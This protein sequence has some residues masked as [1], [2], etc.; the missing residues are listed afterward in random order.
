MAEQN[1]RII[2]DRTEESLEMIKCATERKMLKLYLAFN[3]EEKSNILPKI[4]VLFQHSRKNA[5]CLFQYCFPEK[6]EKKQRNG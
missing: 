6:Q 1:S 2:G 3:G 4:A 5:D